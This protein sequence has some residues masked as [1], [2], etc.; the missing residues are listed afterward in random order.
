MANWAIGPATPVPRS[1][2]HELVEGGQQREQL[3]VAS[4]AELL[5]RARV[6]RRAK[7]V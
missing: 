3:P 6:A 1:K 4:R 7:H 2:M 5:H